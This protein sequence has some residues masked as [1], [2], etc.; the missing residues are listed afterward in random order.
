MWLATVLRS[1]PLA[2]TTTH[3][4]DFLSFFSLEICSLSSHRLGTNLDCCVVVVWF[5]YFHD[6]MH[7]STS[8]SLAAPVPLYLSW[9]HRF[10]FTYDS[11]YT[12]S[13]ILTLCFSLMGDNGRT[14]QA[15]YSFLIG[16]YANPFFFY[17]MPLVLLFFFFY[18]FIYYIYFF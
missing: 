7:E 6:R 1:F 8:S 18:L 16:F 4:T 9:L 10:L 11:L 17:L 12:N 2:L 3:N 13:S 5:F 15:S 14:L